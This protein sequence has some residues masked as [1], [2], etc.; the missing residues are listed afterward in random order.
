MQSPH[1]LPIECFSSTTATEKKSIENAKVERHQYGFVDSAVI[2][3][4]PRQLSC[5]DKVWSFMPLHTQ[6]SALACTIGSNI[7]SVIAF[8]SVRSF[9]IFSCSP[10]TG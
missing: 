9:L 7:G 2:H 3:L 6:A 10:P 4:C 5:S 8:N 1:R